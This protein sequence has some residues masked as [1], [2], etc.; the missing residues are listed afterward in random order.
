M[1]LF[2]FYLAYRLWHLKMALGDLADSLLDWENQ[3]YDS[4]RFESRDKTI[5]QSKQN[6]VGLRQKYARLQ[7]QW[8]QLRQILILIRLLPLTGRWTQHIYQARRKKI[9]NNDDPRG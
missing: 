6:I 7:G 4:L 9:R 3:V 5:S 2:G 8:N 1:A